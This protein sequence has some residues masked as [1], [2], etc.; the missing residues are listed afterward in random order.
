MLPFSPEYRPLGA[1]AYH[2][3]PVHGW[4]WCMGWSDWC[5]RCRYCSNAL[6]WKCHPHQYHTPVGVG[7]NERVIYSKCSMYKLG[8]DPMAAPSLV[9]I[10]FEHEISRIKAR[11]QKP[12]DLIWVEVCSN[13]PAKILRELLS[14]FL[15]CFLS[16]V[17][18]GSDIK[19]YQTLWGEHFQVLELLD[20]IPSIHNVVFSASH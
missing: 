3:L 12:D 1:I 16:G 7:A 10:P 18:K 8:T 4:T 15:H 17:K 13:L 6:W 5:V 2:P 11:P 14:D 19:R 9:K 20:T